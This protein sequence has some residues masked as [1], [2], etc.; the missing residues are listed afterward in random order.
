MNDK[1]SKLYKIVE[2]VVSCCATDI[3]DKPNITPEDV[4]GKNRVENVVM[5]RQIVVMQL[6]HAGYTISTIAQILHCTPANVRKLLS[7][8]YEN[9]KNLRAFNIAYSE[10]TMKC[11]DIVGI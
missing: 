5:T 7:D 3:D 9:L 2:A 11:K 6:G 4:L 8:G 10:S 1:E